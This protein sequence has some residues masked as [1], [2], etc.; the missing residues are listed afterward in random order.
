MAP[1][2]QQYGTWFK[3]RRHPAAAIAVLMEQMLEHGVN[4]EASSRL[5]FMYAYRPA[6]ATSPQD[7]TAVKCI[8]E[9]QD[10]N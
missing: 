10:G 2:Q 8:Y 1:K 7:M 4:L 6:D 3:G 9:E 5:E